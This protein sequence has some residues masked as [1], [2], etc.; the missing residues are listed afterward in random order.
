MYRPPNTNRGQYFGNTGQKEYP[1]QGIHTIAKLRVYIGRLLSF[2][3]VILQCN[4]LCAVQLARHLNFMVQLYHNW[5]FL[6]LFSS[7]KSIVIEKDSNVQVF[8]SA[9]L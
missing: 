3:R 9:G 2:G 1:V 5:H 4:E 7:S 8:I 6:L